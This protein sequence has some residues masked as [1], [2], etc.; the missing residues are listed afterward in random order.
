MHTSM[1]PNVK[2]KKSIK[3]QLEQ[4]VDK[5]ETPEVAKAAAE[6]NEA[7]REIVAFLPTLNATTVEGAKQLFQDIDQRL[8]SV[9]HRLGAHETATKNLTSSKPS[10]ANLPMISEQHHTQQ[11]AGKRYK[12]S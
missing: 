12:K 3:A 2:Q 1:M 5:L 4:I 6:I 9:L 8:T 10:F 7:K 11:P